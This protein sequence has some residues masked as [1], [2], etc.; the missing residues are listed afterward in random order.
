MALSGAV[1]AVA[2]AGGVP[3]LH[4]APDG[5]AWVLWRIA[6]LPAHLAVLA[7]F[8]AAARRFEGPWEFPRP[9]KAAVVALA[10]G[11]AAYA[12]VL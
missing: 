12:A 6:W 3:G 9:V 4:D 8:V 7:G 2:S 5:L 10:A 1:L 11:F